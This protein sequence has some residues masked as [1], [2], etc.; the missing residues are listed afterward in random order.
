M[1]KAAVEL[2]A[3]IAYVLAGI[4]VIA[5]IGLIHSYGAYESGRYGDEPIINWPLI[6]GC[7]ASSL[8]SILFAVMF[9]V[10]RYMYIGKACT[11]EE[12][13]EERIEE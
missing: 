12:G 10:V 5:S 13:Y 7:V 2:W 1:S 3:T 11:S 9:S 4:I 8:Y 6:A